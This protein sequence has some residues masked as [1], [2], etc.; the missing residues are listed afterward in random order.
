MFLWPNLF[1]IVCIEID[2]MTY[3]FRPAFASAAVFTASMLD[4][5]ECFVCQ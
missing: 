5:T 1:E 4:C 3:V 2:H